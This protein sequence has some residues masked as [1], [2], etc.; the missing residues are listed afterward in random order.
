MELQGLG[1][2][3]EC[4]IVLFFVQYEDKRSEQKNKDN[5]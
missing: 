3:L 5:D 4:E 2:N 1:T